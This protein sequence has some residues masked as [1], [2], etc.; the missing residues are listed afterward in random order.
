MST[1]GKYLS[2]SYKLPTSSIA[3]PESGIKEQRRVLYWETRENFR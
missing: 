2:T 1:L 3:G